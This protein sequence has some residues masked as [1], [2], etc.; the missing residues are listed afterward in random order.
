MSIYIGYQ[1]SSYY[2]QVICQGFLCIW[3][4]FFR[5]IVRLL[6]YYFYFRRER[7][8][9]FW[10]VFVFIKVV[11]MGFRFFCLV[12]RYLIGNRC[13]VGFFL[14][15]VFTV[16]WGLYFGGSFFR[17]CFLFFCLRDCQRFSRFFVFGKF[18]QCLFY[19]VEFSF[20]FSQISLSFELFISYF[21]CVMFFF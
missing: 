12:L 20:F 17:Y 6:F 21:V 15:V 7:Y 11:G 13:N 10:V 4:N 19:L 1:L 9:C 16:F 3:F 18:C 14:L 8:G 5:F 2:M